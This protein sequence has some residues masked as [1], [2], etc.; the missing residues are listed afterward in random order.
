MFCGPT[1]KK[2]K[3]AP[4]P[5]AKH[6]IPVSCV[7]FVDLKREMV[8]PG[9]QFNTLKERKFNQM[10]PL[11]LRSDRRTN[12]LNAS[13]FG[14]EKSR[15][16]GDNFKRFGASFPSRPCPFLPNDNLPP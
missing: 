12:A 14:V 8:G 6:H 13:P 2:A 11:K 9:R 16:V 10:K 5:A 1:F 7:N 3:F 15:E 4:T